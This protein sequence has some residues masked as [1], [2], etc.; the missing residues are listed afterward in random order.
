MG[1][2]GHCRPGARESAVTAA[3]CRAR[4]RVL[5][6]PLAAVSQETRGELYNCE[7]RKHPSQKEEKVCPKGRVMPPCPPRG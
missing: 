5:G 4:V 2:L 3:W 6:T 7:I 1:E